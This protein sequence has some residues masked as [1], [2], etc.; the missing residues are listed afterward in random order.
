M[1]GGSC[2]FV[3]TVSSCSSQFQKSGIL[4]NCERA[5]PYKFYFKNFFFV[6]NVLH[7]FISKF[8]LELLCFSII[9]AEELQVFEIEIL[10]GLIE[11]V[12]NLGFVLA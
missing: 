12:A 7:R 10:T 11:V 9:V 3:R 6:I 1:F 2:C 8:Y 5:L 4:A